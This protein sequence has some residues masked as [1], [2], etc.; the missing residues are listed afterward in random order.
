MLLSFK[1]RMLTIEKHNGS[2]KCTLTSDMSLVELFSGCSRTCLCMP[3]FP[4]PT[5]LPSLRGS[6]YPMRHAWKPRGSRQ[7]GCPHAGRALRRGI[8]R[9][10]ERRGA[11]IRFPAPGPPNR[12]RGAPCPQARVCRDQNYAQRII[13]RD[14][15][16]SVSVY[17]TFGE[18]DW[19]A[20]EL[21]DAA[22]KTEKSTAII[23][24][25]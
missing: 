23:G 16:S 21:S 6:F 4:L 15:G 18:P 11:R 12:C 7:A 5:R 9:N 13:F 24:A 17:I 1:I 2:I 19:D 22:E 3:G 14:N 8:H 25:V 20:P 10:G